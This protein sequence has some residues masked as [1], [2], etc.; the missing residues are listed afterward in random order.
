MVTRRVKSSFLLLSICRIDLIDGV[1]ADLAAHEHRSDS[2]H[3]VILFKQVL[4]HNKVGE[5]KLEK[6]HV[7]SSSF[8]LLRS[9]LVLV[10]NYLRLAKLWISLDFLNW[11]IILDF[12]VGG[13]DLFG[14][15]IDGC[16]LL[17]FLFFVFDD[18]V[19]PDFLSKARSLDH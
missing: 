5:A 8:F 12:F 2:V 15:I 14:N 4:I 18:N 6:C 1:D 19:A 7:V 11:S 3:I 9:L 16:R 13:I 10:F 17:N